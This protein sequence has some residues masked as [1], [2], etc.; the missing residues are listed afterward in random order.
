MKKDLNIEEKKVRVVKVKKPRFDMDGMIDV[1]SIP[2]KGKWEK[3]C[4]G[5]TTE[6]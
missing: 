2:N 3:L 4:I 1:P 5:K 6:Q